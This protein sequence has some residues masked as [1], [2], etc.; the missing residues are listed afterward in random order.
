MSA[1]ADIATQARRLREQTCKLLDLKPDDLTLTQKLRVNRASALRIQ[2]DDLEAAQLRGEQIDINKLIEASEA[3]ERLLGGDPEQSPQHDFAG[4][5]AELAAL[6]NLRSVARDRATAAV[7]S[8]LAGITIYMADF[9]TARDALDQLLSD[10]LSGD[11]R[12]K[13]VAAMREA[14][15]AIDD[16]VEQIKVAPVAEAKPAP[17][18]TKPPPQPQPIEDGAA[19]ANAT[20]PPDHYLKG[21]D[22][23]WR[24]YVG[25][26]GVISPWRRF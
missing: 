11:L 2:I 12:T 4:A 24:R 19:R 17:V 15:A 8:A 20:R 26:D 1:V 9:D 25:V 23:D 16:P 13:F 7:T 6:L 14:G 5:Q 22:E 3:L 18:P 10:L 21:P